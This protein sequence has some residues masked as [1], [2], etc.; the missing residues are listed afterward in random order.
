MI[1]RPF[2]FSPETFRRLSG[3]IKPHLYFANFFFVCWLRKS[4]YVFVV[5]TFC[6]CYVH[7]NK[8]HR[9]FYQT[10]DQ[11]SK[12]TLLCQECTSTSPLESSN[13]TLD[14]CLKEESSSCSHHCDADHGSREVEGRQ[15][16]TTVFLPAQLLAHK[17]RPCHIS[18][19]SS[20]NFVSGTEVTNLSVAY[21]S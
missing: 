10:F 6:F 19:F 11:I 18:G 21:C 20:M 5:T 16:D 3:P 13:D 9:Q 8:T 15:T 12:R 1:L 2:P 7:E 17:Q 4:L 14:Y